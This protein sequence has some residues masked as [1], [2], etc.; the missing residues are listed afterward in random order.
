MWVF[1]TKLMEELFRFLRHRNFL[2]LLGTAALSYG[3]V[4]F[5]QIKELIEL[6]KEF[7]R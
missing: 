6:V 4:N 2:Y 1:L 7:F 5:A 3:V